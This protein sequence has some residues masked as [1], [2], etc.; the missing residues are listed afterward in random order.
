[1]QFC[2]KVSY[3]LICKQKQYVNIL[4][5][6]KDINQDFI[7]VKSLLAWSQSVKKKYHWPCKSTIQN[8]DK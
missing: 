1:M 2:K 4:K 6:G 7:Q 5:S 8:W 3:F